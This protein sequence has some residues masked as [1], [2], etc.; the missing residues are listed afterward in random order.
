R[1]AA[2]RQARG[3][4]GPGEGRDPALLRCFAASEGAFAIRAS[5]A[6][7]GIHMSREVFLRGGWAVQGELERVRDLARDSCLRGANRPII[8]QIFFPEEMFEQR[9]RIDGL[10][11]FALV[12]VTV[13]GV[14][15]VARSAVCAH[16][17]NRSL[18]KCRPTACPRAPH[19][20]CRGLGCGE[21]VDAVTGHR[22]HLVGGCPT[23]EIPWW[24]PR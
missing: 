4:P 22:R 5:I 9:N 23:V 8:E 1:V 13:A 20:L 18:N 14:G 19:G 24:L 15:V 16:A 6:S 12:E 10:P 2:P 11:V 3:P 7:V 17:I 21:H